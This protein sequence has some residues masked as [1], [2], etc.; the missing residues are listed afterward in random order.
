MKTIK[1]KVDGMHC[2]G[3]SGRLKRTLEALPQVESCEANHETKDVVV[4]LKEEL[5]VEA[6][7][8]VLADGGF[9]VL[10]VD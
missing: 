6:I 4:T 9:T 7:T 5:S 2:G 8:K 3:C 10:S 1:M